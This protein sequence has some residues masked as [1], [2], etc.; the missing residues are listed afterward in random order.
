VSHQSFDM[1]ILLKIRKAA[2]AVLISCV[3]LLCRAAD[4]RLE[5]EARWQLEFSDL[6][7]MLETMGTGEKPPARLTVRM[8]INYSVDGKFPLFVFLNGGGGGRG[9]TLPLDQRT[10]GS[11]DFIC[12]NLPLFKRAL[13]KDRGA[14]ITVDDFEILSHAYHAMLQKLLD[15]IPNVTPER[16]AFGGFSNGAHAVALLVAGHDDFILSRFRAFYSIEGG[17]PLAANA[18]SD[19]ALRACRLFLMHG[20]EPKD[21][22]ERIAYNLLANELEVLA[23]THGLDFKVITMRD[24]GHGLPPQYQ[25]V[26]G[27]WVRGEKI[28]EEEKK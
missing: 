1:R 10:V 13:N 26:L 28:M 21:D 22:P 15:T 8:P 19:P 18:L 16:S 3:P 9:D 5:P 25:Q 12:V 6:P 4:S 27:K 14:L 17:S 11:N 2:L 7:E 20:D 23:K 24:T